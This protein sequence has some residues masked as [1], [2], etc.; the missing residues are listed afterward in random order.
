MSNFN[1][2]RKKPVMG[3][4]LFNFAIVLQP[5][6]SGNCKVEHLIFMC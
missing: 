4:E 3:V 6:T 5:N 1:F 2:V